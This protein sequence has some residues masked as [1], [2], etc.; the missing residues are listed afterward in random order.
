MSFIGRL[1]H[2]PVWVSHRA[3]STCRG[4]PLVLRRSPCRSSSC[5]TAMT[6][7]AHPGGSSGWVEVAAKHTSILISIEWQGRKA[8]D[9]TFAAIGENGTTAILDRLLA[10]CPQIDP[11]RVVIYWPLPAGAINSF[12]YRVN[13]VKR[14]AGVAGRQQPGARTADT[15]APL[16]RSLR[17]RPPSVI[18]CRPH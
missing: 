2:L 14:I 6:R 13:N 11:G 16:P 18:A 17:R 10:K 4:K 8:Q 3:M 12:S 5:C 9:T 7:S 1:L 15:G